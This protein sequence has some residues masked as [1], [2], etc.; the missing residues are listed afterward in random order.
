MYLR[1]T[2]QDPNFAYNVEQ[3]YQNARALEMRVLVRLN[4]GVGMHSKNLHYARLVG[5]QEEILEIDGYRYPLD[6]VAEVR[7]RIDVEN[8]YTL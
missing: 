2:P 1:L 5:P 7:Y 3:L 4:S 8:G 6:R